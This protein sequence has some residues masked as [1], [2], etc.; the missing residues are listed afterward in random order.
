MKTYRVDAP[1]PELGRVLERL[2]KE[3]GVGETAAIR[4]KWRY[5]AND[6]ANI[7]KM[8]GLDVISIA[9]E[10]G[11]VVVTVVRRR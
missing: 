8:I 4:S 3:V 1:C 6:V 9:D 11:D 7:A 10:A 2:I 5:I